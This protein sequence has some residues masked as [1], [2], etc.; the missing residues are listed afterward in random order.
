MLKFI[1]SLIGVDVTWFEIV[2]GI[3]LAIVFYVGLVLILSI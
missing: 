3:S 2:L 1:S